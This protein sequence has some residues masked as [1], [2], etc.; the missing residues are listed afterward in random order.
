MPTVLKFDC[1]RHEAT[2]RYEFC[3]HKVCFKDGQRNSYEWV[4]KVGRSTQ[5][6]HDSSAYGGAQPG[7]VCPT[8]PGCTYIEQSVNQSD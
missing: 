5:H 8:G 1:Q 7:P 2:P 3:R 4:P 6:L